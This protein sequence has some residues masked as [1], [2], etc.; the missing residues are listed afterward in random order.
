[1]TRRDV[2]RT[3]S[4]RVQRTYGHI[5]E[6][7]SSS[8]FLHWE[9]TEIGSGGDRRC[10]RLLLI[11]SDTDMRKEYH[12]YWKTHVCQLAIDGGLDNAR[13]DR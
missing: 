1:M 2:H 13:W 7:E 6:N 3:A 8:D 4:V 9:T 10:D 11:S 5:V 12:M